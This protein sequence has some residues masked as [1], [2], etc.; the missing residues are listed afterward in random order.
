MGCAFSVG[1]PILWN[2]TPSKGSMVTHAGLSWTA[3]ILVFLW[4]IGPR[5]LITS[6]LITCHLPLLVFGDFKPF[7]YIDNCLRKLELLILPTKKA[8]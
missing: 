7:I 1:L 8:S 5:H 4:V 3:E 6:T 2:S